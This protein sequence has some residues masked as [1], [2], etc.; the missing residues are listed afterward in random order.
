MFR[1]IFKNPKIV[2]LLL[3][4]VSLLSIPLYRFEKEVSQFPFATLYQGKVTD[5]RCS[6]RQSR[7]RSSVVV[8]LDG[9]TILGYR[10]ARA[11]CD[12]LQLEDHIGNNLVGYYFRGADLRQVIDGESVVTYD[13]RREFI[14]IAVFVFFTFPP[15]L[16]LLIQIKKENDILTPDS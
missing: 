9:E 6:Y 5:V 16:L 13:S 12:E 7:N 4:V 11:S 8:E 14:N 1:T 3:V 2:K 15:L 10:A